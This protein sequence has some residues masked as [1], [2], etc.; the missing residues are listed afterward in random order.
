MSRVFIFLVRL[1]QGT[2]AGFLG[3]NCRFY[4]SCSCYAIE[5]LETHGGL[6][7]FWLSL[8][9]VARCH[10]FHPGGVDP[11]PPARSD[12]RSP[13]AISREHAA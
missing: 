8:R 9:R 5:A 13:L 2:L 10:P 1:Y 6:R 7:G 3:G 4:P 11:V 12:E